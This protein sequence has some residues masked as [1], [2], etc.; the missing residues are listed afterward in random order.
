MLL[1]KAHKFLRKA[2]LLI[3]PPITDGV[4]VLAILCFEL[5]MTTQAQ[6]VATQAQSIMAHE[7]REVGPRVQQNASTMVSHDKV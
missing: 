7:N 1:L 2:N 3:H 4:I 5:V 6:A